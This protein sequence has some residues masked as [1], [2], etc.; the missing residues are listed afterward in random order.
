MKALVFHQ[1]GDADVLSVEE[2]PTPEPASGEVQVRVQAAALNHLDVWVRKGW[3][4]LRLDMPHIGGAD[5]AGTVS[6][7]G[8]EVSDVKEGDRVAICPGYA[9]TDDEFTRRGEH[10]LSPRFRILGEGR[11]GTFA[12]YVTV[13]EHA[14]LPMPAQADFEETA[15]VQLVFLTAWRMLITQ[16]KLRPGETVLIIGAGGGVNSASIQ[17]AKLAGAEVFALTSSAEKMEK[18]QAL[19]ADHVFDYTGSNWLEWIQELAGKRGVDVVVD[20]VGRATFQNSLQALRRGGRLLTVGTTS[21]PKFDVDLRYVFYKQLHVIGSTMGS[22]EDFRQVM[23]Q[24]WAGRLRAVID[25][26]LPLDQGREGHV[27]LEEGTQFGKILLKP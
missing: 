18:A 15:A 3:P 26:V 11:P 22:P 1:H 12:E 23:A 7:V 8:S 20:N 14:L 13:P 6:G 2:T 21:G 25:R 27:V 19:G 17:I 16:G 4:G 9:T 5:G 10:S 24:V